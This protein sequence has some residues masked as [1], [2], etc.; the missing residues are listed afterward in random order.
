MSQ[1]PKT[2]RFRGLTL[3]CSNA[4]FY[5]AVR[6]GEA[7]G[8]QMCFRLSILCLWIFVAE[9]SVW[10]FIFLNLRK[11]PYRWIESVVCIVLKV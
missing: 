9:V 10:C 8:R 2:H 4:G 3:L 6:D 11:T 1:A 5:L 7:H